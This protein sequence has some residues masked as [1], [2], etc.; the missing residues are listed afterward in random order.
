MI[1]ITI[2]LVSLVGAVI[3]VIFAGIAN[4]QLQEAREGT[5]LE[6][7]G[8]VVLRQFEDEKTPETVVTAMEA[9]QR[10]KALVKGGKPLEKYP[11]T[12]PV[13]ALNSV[14]N[15]PKR[16]TL[17]GH[18]D[19]IRHASFSPDGQHIVTASSDGTARVWHI[20]G[21]LLQ[22]LQGH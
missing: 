2:L 4:Q 3:A 17:Q 10:L 15:L 13:W 11:T 21:K 18:Q 1:G 5:E 16:K 8:N 6:R 22:T 9:G 20:N 12:S 19:R 7:L 14:L